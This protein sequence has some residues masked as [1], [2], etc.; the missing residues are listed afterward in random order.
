MTVEQWLNDNEIGL[1][2]WHKKYQHDNESFDGWLDRVS[3][4]DSK[5]RDLIEQKKFLPGGRILATRGIPQKTGNKGTYFNCYVLPPVQDNIE[6]IWDTAKEMARTYSYGGGVGIDISGLAPEGATVRNAARCSSGATTFM[7]LYSV[8]TGTIGQQGRRGA[9]MI[10]MSCDHPDIEKFIDIKN[11]LDN[12][13]YANISVRASDEFMQSAQNGENYTLSFR[14]EATGEVTERRV[15]A[16]ELLRKLAENN[17]RTGE[18]GIL[19]W[20][21]IREWSLL[22]EYEDFEFA[23]TNPCGEEP[24]PAYGACCLGSINLSQYVLNPFTP[25]AVFDLDSFQYDVHVCVDALNDILEEGMPYHPLE[26]QKKCAADWRQIGLGIM[27]LGDMLI[28]LGLRYGSD[29]AQRFCSEV[30][31]VMARAAIEESERLA[32]VRPNGAFPKFDAEALSKSEFY[33]EHTDYQRLDAH[34]VK[35]MRNSQLLTAAP[36]GSISTMIGVSGGIEPLFARSYKRTTKSLHGDQDVVYEMHPQVIEECMAALGCK[37]ADELPDYCITAQEIPY[38]ERV[39]MQTSLQLHIDA[40]ISS[41]VNLPNSATVEDIMDL[42]LKAWRYGCKGITVFRDGCERAAILTTG[43]EATAQPAQ[44]IPRGVIMEVPERQES[45]QFKIKTACGSLYITVSHDEN[46]DITNCYTSIGD[47]GCRCNTEA[48]SRMVSTAIRGGTPIEYIIR[49]LKKA[50]GCASWQHALGAGKK[51]SPG[52]SCPSA[53][54][55]VLETVLAER[56]G[57]GEDEESAPAKVSVKE[58]VSDTKPERTADNGIWCPQCGESLHHESG[59]VICNN[60]G[61][62]HCG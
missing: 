2:I 27:G 7:E 39:G 32:E 19:F 26:G 61:W 22:S 23:G 43:E 52:S 60:C 50:K 31:D 35:P 6:S 49:Q 47:G 1:D 38:E 42:Y 54:A 20:D 57:D 53:I 16:R 44:E 62:S 29:E 46:G 14:R 33:Q 13:N 18:P 45:E 48:V 25:D 24:L 8:T 12:V 4:G 36:T 58:P 9:L 37:S 34:Q 59:C 10:S 30:G 5:L 3:G 11:N 28:K 55:H 15:N 17:W 41:T 51:L 56:G 21:R 40:S